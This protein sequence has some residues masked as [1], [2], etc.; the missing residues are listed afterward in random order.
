L[1]LL[2]GIGL[3]TFFAKNN[4]A[5]ASA[6]LK[7]NSTCRFLCSYTINTK[8]TRILTMTAFSRGRTLFYL[9]SRTIRPPPSCPQCIYPDQQY[10]VFSSSMTIRYASKAPPK[11]IA[12]KMAHPIRKSPTIAS[13]TPLKSAPPQTG[14]ASVLRPNIATTASTTAPNH[15]TPVTNARISKIVPSQISPQ[16]LNALLSVPEPIYVSPSF[17]TYTTASYS[18]SF[19]FMGY[20]GYALT[21]WG[22]PPVGISPYVTFGYG[23]SSLVL[24]FVGCFTLS[25]TTKLIRSITAVPT[26]SS[27]LHLRITSSRFVPWSTKTVEVPLSDVYLDKSVQEQLLSAGYRKER[28]PLS[29]VSIF[30]RPWVWMGRGLADFGLQTRSMFVREHMVKMIIKGEGGWK[31]DVRG[32]ALGG[33]EGWFT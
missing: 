22:A 12:Q 7:S 20:G 30:L 8:N 4:R 14:A 10:R 13:K 3:W 17:K 25:A 27:Q 1:E 16:T 6:S 31:L 33:A 11:P 24:F 5:T 2:V 19:F 32:M 15:Q 28:G 29:E 26:K 23:V 9:T 21:F 18:L